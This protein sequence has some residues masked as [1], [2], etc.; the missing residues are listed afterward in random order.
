MTHK[1][2]ENFWKHFC[3][4]NDYS[5]IEGSEV[6]WVAALAWSHGWAAGSNDIKRKIK[7]IMN[8]RRIEDS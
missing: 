8:E 1:T 3:E 7:G 5:P 2:F 4:E 6:H